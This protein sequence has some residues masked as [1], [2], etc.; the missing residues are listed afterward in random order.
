MFFPR[1]NLILLLSALSLVACGSGDKTTTSQI[2]DEDVSSSETFVSSSSLKVSFSSET[3]VSSS[4]SEHSSSSKKSV[5]SSSSKGLSSS[6][7]SVTNS[8]SIGLSSSEVPGSS[9]S[10]KVSSSSSVVIPSYSYPDWANCVSEGRC[11]TF[12]DS[13][14]DHVYKTVTIGTQTW[15]AE[16]LAYLPSVNKLPEYSGFDAMYYVYDYDGTDVDEAKTSSYYTAYGA[17]YNWLAAKDACPTGWHLPDTT[18]WNTLVD[19]ASGN[20]TAAPKLKSVSGWTSNTGTDAYGF[21][22]LPGGWCNLGTG[23]GFYY[24]LSNAYWWTATKYDSGNAYQRGVSY[25]YTF[26]TTYHN[27]MTNGRSVRCIQ[28]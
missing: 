7:M 24:V 23:T 9:S 26:V 12:T 8:S 1:C 19:Y 3:S 15:M 21:S 27:I 18:E 20:S 10:M 2:D 14:D 11:G 28:D 13:R 22:A 5:F 25:D 17:L 4:F 16:N 6:E